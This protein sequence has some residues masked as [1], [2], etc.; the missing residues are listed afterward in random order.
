MIAASDT[1]LAN[2]LRSGLAW[3]EDE[4]ARSRKVADALSDLILPHRP[5]LGIGYFRLAGVAAHAELNRMFAAE[6]QDLIRFSRE[7]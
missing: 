5:N 7:A 3:G 2:V 1:A 4:I 6:E